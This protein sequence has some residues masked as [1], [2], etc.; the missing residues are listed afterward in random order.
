MNTLPRSAKVAAQALLS[1]LLVVAV[2][3][4][5]AHVPAHA[6][7]PSQSYPPLRV[8]TS[9][10]SLLVRNFSLCNP[11]LYG[12]TGGAAYGT[13]YETLYI[14]DYAR[15][16]EHPMLAS[17]YQWSKD[18]KTLTFTIRQGVRWSDGVPF[19][20]RDVYFTFWTLPKKTGLCDELG[21]TGKKAAVTGV[22]M[23]APDQVAI[24]FAAVD[25]TR[26]FSLVN[27][28]WITP[29]HQYSQHLKDMATWTDPNPVGTEPVPRL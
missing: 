7:H 1:G 23:P 13:I 15:Y 19:S 11:N 20:A 16:V 22:T 28:S 9:I 24:H 18:L 10:G 4:G 8:E 25:V 6:A 26:F 5:P 29:E 21:V 27:G 3:L 2:A 14:V 17:S 12:G